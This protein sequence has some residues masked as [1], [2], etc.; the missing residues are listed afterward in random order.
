MSQ[1][2]EKLKRL[3]AELF[4]LDQ[5]ELDFG[6]YRIMNTK[7]AEITRFLD[8]DL[9][10]QVRDVL[11]Q[12]EKDSRAAIAED[13]EKAMEQAKALGF[14]DPAQAPRVKE[15]Q[16]RYNAAF[17]LEAAESEVYSHLYNFFRRYY[18]E[19]DFISQ[20]RYKEG[21][22]AIPYEGEEVK[23]YWANHDQ[24]YIKTSEYLRN[25]TFTLP[26]GKRVHF[27]LT[28]ADTEKNNNRP[29]AGNER[30]FILSAEQPLAEKNGELVIRFEFKP[31]PQKRKQADLNAAAVNRILNHTTGFDDW[32]RELASLR[33]T[34]KNPNRTL[35]EKHL[36]DYTARNT[37]D[38]FIHKDLGGFLRRELDFYIKN[39]VMHLDDIE[40]ETA[41][42][43]EQ[44]LAKIKAIRRI[45]H[46]IIDFLAQIENFQKKLWLKKKFVVETQYCITL[47]RILAIEDEKTRD[48]LLDQIIANDVQ[49]Q[50]WQ[51]LY[52]ITTPSPPWGEGQGVGTSPSPL[53]GEGW[54]EGPSLSPIQGEG[55]G[56][57]TSPSPPWGEGRGEGPKSRTKAERNALL[58]AFAREMRNAP[59][60]AEK[61]LWH[62]LRD[63]RLAGYKF[64]RQHPMAGYIAD[65]VC[66]EARLVIELDGGQHAE[67]FQQER[68]AARTREFERRGFRVLRFW[69]NEVLSNT[70]GVLQSILDALESAP[71]HTP[72][73][74]PHPDPLPSG[75][76][77]EVA[78]LKAHP[79]LVVDTRHFDEAFKLRLLAAIPDLDEE[80]DGLL[81]HSENFQALNLLQARYREQV[82]C[83]YIDPP[84]NTGSDNDFAYKDRYQHA[85][86]LSMMADRA[87]LSRSLAVP[88]CGLLVSTDDGEY[89]NLRLLLEQS[90]GDDNFVADVIWNSRKSVSS[91]ALISVATNHT[92]FFAKDREELE[93][94]KTTFRLPQKEEGFANPDNDPRGP[95]KLD[96]MD[97]PNV[98]ENLTYPIKNPLTGEEFYPPEGRHWRFERWQTE[99]LLMEGRIVFGR[100]G[101]AKPMYKRFLSE[102]KERG[103]TPTTLWDDVNTTTDATKLLLDLFGDAISRELINKLKPKPNELVERC[104]VLLTNGQGL[105]L[106]Y[107]AGS[108]T[109]GHAVINLNREDG[110]RRKFIL[111]EMGEYFDTVLV[112]RIKKVIFSPEWKDGKPLTPA[113]SPKGRGLGDD[114]YSPKGRGSEEVAHSH[115]GSG[116]GEVADSPEVR[117]FGDV[118]VF[119]EGSGSGDFTLAPE[120]RGSSEAAGEGTW[121]QRSPRII[122]ILRL[123]SYEDTLNNLELTRTDAQQRALEE[124]DAFREDYVLRYMLDVESRGSASLL[125]IERFEDPL[126]YT[127]NIATGTAGE[128]KPT[129]VDLVETFNYLIGIRVKT[130]DHIGGVRVVTGTNPQGERVLI[131]WRNTKEMDN[132]ALDAWFRKQG[133]NTKD[134][135]YDVIYVNGDNNLE[136]LR[137][138][139]QTWKVRLIEEEFRRLMFDVQDV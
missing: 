84:Y 121:V 68:D 40:S 44:Y 27:K 38:Y 105:V 99:Q 122:K 60:D 119:P 32:R 94:L 124:H 100:R 20:R 33:P 90:W 41:P 82:K 74:N 107:F 106:D 2:L 130:I 69:N 110:G 128:T 66:I 29:A 52:H 86:W 26:S 48:W 113:L 67:L 43:V 1:Q 19:G 42:R 139:D 57:G 54:G 24:Y 96:P 11:T 55:W 59:T 87:E 46:K 111:V 28:E 34:E 132:D 112:P 129:V 23:L 65:F 6:I 93:K 25:Y 63:R 30:R 16:A 125:N 17:D 72:H 50:E 80:T 9:L 114:A 126:N 35:L 15:L 12:Y 62:F 135:E 83:I 47:D 51:H 137:R 104:A 115:T 21:V 53:W 131:L 98:R 75:E 117:G 76:R 73:S 116:F 92:T 109:T 120:G 45:A 102:A 13:L 95:W 81:V 36:T 79:T 39:E 103:R 70:M 8:N 101:T 77:E 64:R 56:E 10:P 18:S 5:A 49:R 22:Y 4:Q 127:L 123:E 91:D 138:P 31:E 14:D 118:A 61:R 89:A 108:G 7:R 3:L 71:H 37:F 88:S 134:Q 85:S 58:K 97:A 78:F 133:Y 136:N